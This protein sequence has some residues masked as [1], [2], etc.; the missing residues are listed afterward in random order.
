MHD[1]RKQHGPDMIGEPGRMLE[2]G[3]HLRQELPGLAGRQDDV[4]GHQR[5]AWMRGI[6]ADF[7]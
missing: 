3:W 5:R 1:G 7:P 6:H 4:P 2:L